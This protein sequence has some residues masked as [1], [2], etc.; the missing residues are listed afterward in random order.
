MTAFIKLNHYNV[1]ATVGRLLQELNSGDE[2]VLL[3]LVRWYGEQA[4]P[5]VAES[6]FPLVLIHDWC[7]F[8]SACYAIWRAEEEQNCPKIQ[9]LNKATA[10]AKIL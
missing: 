5:Y 4:V 1:S 3:L 6:V 2:L 10:V 9:F 8:L 7:C